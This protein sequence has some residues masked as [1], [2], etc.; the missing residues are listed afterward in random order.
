MYVRGCYILLIALGGNQAT[1][2]LAQ[3]M[4]WRNIV[5]KVMIT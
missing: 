1:N 4:K 5:F 3:Y 2:Y